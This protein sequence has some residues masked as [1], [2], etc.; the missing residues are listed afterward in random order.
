MSSEIR[1]IDWV[2]PAHYF[3]E[4]KADWYW[5]L[6]ILTVAGAITAVYLGNI[7]FGL[8]ILLS[9]LIMSL[10]ANREPETI[11]FAVTT[12]GVQV[13]EVLY[14]YSTLESFYIETNN[15]QGPLLLLKSER[16]FMHLIVLPIPIDY[17]DEI[18]SI[19]EQRLPQ[20]H[21]EEPLGN[22]ILELLGF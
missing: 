13:D 14:P 16:T 10:M 17:I 9:G 19:I 15:P 22:K 4:K 8:L 5:A 21:L 3:I 12:R 6:G 1:S 11:P 7:L 20:E 2:A 18:E